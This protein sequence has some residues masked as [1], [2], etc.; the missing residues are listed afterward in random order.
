M[1]KATDTDVATAITQWI[2][3][4]SVETDLSGWTGL[5]SSRS[6]IT[7]ATGDGYLSSASLQV[8]NKGTA[9]GAAGVNAKPRPV[10][11][12]TSG[13][14]YTATVWVR[15]QTAGQVLYLQ[16]KE[17]RPGGATVAARNVRYQLPD[18]NWHQLSVTYSAASAGDQLAMSI[19][20]GNLAPRPGST[21]TRCA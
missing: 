12:T 20:C 2:A 19:Y 17:Y 16:L 4:Q 13:T 10:T 7:R 15:G 21:P 9:R 6:A 3:N 8:A 18:T 1:C 11:A 14:P 5:Y